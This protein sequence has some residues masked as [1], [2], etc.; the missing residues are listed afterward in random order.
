MQDLFTELDGDQDGQLSREEIKYNAKRFSDKLVECEVVGSMSEAAVAA[1]VKSFLAAVDG[2]G[3]EGLS[4]AEVEGAF[5]RSAPFPDERALA[6]EVQLGTSA[7]QIDE[8]ENCLWKL[9]KHT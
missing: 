6:Q 9:V 5:L 8:L 3:E 1:Q 2:V 7:K 4:W